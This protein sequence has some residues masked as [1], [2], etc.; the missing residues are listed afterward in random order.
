MRAVLMSLLVIPLALGCGGFK[1]SE[2]PSRVFAMLLAESSQKLSAAADKQAICSFNRPLFWYRL[3]AVSESQRPRR[4]ISA[5]SLT[6][7]L[8]S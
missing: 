8:K 4:L 1:G 2:S 3:T 5:M 6:F 7:P